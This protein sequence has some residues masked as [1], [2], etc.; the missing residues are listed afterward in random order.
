M[1]LLRAVRPSWFM[2]VGLLAVGNWPARSPFG[3]ESTHLS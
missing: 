2:A 1:T 3:W